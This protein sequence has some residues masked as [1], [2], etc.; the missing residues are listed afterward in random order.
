MQ[1]KHKRMLKAKALN[2]KSFFE[3]GSKALIEKDRKVLLSNIAQEIANLIEENGEVN[4]N[5]ICTHNSRRS[6]ISQTWGFYAAHYFDLPIAAYSGGTETTAF[7]RNSVK[8]LKEVGFGFNVVEFSHQNPVYEVTD[9][10]L[11]KKFIAF[12]K[13]FDDPANASP[14][15]AVTTC[16]HADENCPF[17]PEAT[18]RFHLPFVDP[19]HA[20]GTPEQDQAYRRANRTIANELYFLF[21]EVK[22]LLNR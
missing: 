21:A 22:H 11:E 3:R 8:A 18:R 15:V 10:G 12:S 14:F 17:I 4:I 5:F 16:N 2:T 20:D 9:P 13:T 6:Q 1:S 19:K 7:H